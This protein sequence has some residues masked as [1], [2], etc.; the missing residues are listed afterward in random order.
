MINSRHIA[1]ALPWSALDNNRSEIDRD[2]VT[3]IV[4]ETMNDM[5]IDTE[6]KVLASYFS[7]DQNAIARR[8]EAHSKLVE[9]H[10]VLK[11][12]LRE[13]YNSE[14]QLPTAD[15]L[16]DIP[17]EDVLENLER[18]LSKKPI[19]PLVKHRDQ[20]HNLLAL[21]IFGNLGGYPPWTKDVWWPDI[22]LKD[23]HRFLFG[24]IKL[25]AQFRRLQVPAWDRRTWKTSRDRRFELVTAHTRQQERFDFVY[26]EDGMVKRDDAG[27][28]IKE[29]RPAMLV[30]LPSYYR[31]KA[32]TKNGE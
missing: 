20:W 17:V 14:I 21:A 19:P 8:A 2:A 9:F 32:G 1:Q 4:S 25:F 26:E 13:F 12:Q 29:P 11:G 10:R 27:Q 30:S 18:Q 15:G 16:T 24:C 3:R 7:V 5:P 28:P 6:G 31:P 23:Q 22:A